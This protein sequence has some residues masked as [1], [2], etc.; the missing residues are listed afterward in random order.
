[1]SN[2]VLVKVMRGNR[3]ESTHRVAYAVISSEG[4]VIDSAGD[5]DAAVFPRSA[6]KPLQAI[7]LIESGAAGRFGFLD[8]ELALACASHN[9]ETAHLRVLRSMLAK[10]GLGENQ[11]ECG[12]HWPRR[13]ETM[14]ELVLAA[15]EPLPAHNNCSGKHAG[16]LA[17]ALAL[18]VEPKGYIDPSHAVQRTIAGMLCG[19]V[20]CRYRSGAMR[21]RRLFRAYLGDPAA[22]SGARVPALRLR[23]DAE[24]CPP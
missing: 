15:S 9:G 17:L 19:P 7:P 16:M 24:R 10:A 2:P 8:E 6:I 21:D 12:A 18:G 20:R 13:R 4:T 14:R 22:Q 5:I 1:M 3:V 11:L 23:R